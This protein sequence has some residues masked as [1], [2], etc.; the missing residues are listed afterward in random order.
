MFLL[1]IFYVTCKSLG[2]YT[3]TACN[4][5]PNETT[6][7]KQVLSNVQCKEELSNFLARAMSLVQSPVAVFLHMFY[8]L[9]FYLQVHCYV[10]KVSVRCPSHRTFA[11]CW[12]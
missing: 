2:L 10:L 8:L 9:A 1:F 7:S 3:E 6:C 12:P 4:R 11:T 5:I